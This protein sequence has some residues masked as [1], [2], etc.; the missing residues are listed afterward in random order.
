MNLLRHSKLPQRNAN[1]RMQLT[2]QL[3][4]NKMLPKFEPCSKI[5]KKKSNH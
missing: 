5:I 1:V 4:E 2:L 3:G